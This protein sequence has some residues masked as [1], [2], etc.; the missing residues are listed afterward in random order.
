MLVARA[1]HQVVNRTDEGLAAYR[2][3]VERPSWWAVRRRKAPE[4]PM[5]GRFAP[6][7][8]GS[9]VGWTTTW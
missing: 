9:L 8:A 6:G 1:D 4:E 2:S 3:W 5:L 7:S